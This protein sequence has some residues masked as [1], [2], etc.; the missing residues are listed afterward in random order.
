M[1][2]GKTEPSCT[3]RFA[4]WWWRPALVDHGRGGRRAHRASAHHVRAHDSRVQRAPWEA[5]RWR[6]FASAQL[7]TGAAV[8]VQRHHRL[9]AR[10]ELDLGHR[11][12][13]APHALPEE[14]AERV[15]E[16]RRAVAAQHARGRR[17]SPGWKPSRSSAITTCRL[18]N[19]LHP[20]ARGR[21][22]KPGSVMPARI[23]CSG[24]GLELEA[25]RARRRGRDVEEVIRV[26]RLRRAVEAVHRLRHRP[27][28]KPRSDA[29]TCACPTSACGSG[30]A[31][32]QQHRG[33]ADGAGGEDEVARRAGGCGAAR[34]ARPRRPRRAPRTA[35][36]AVAARRRAARRARDARSVAPCA[37][38]AGMVV[39]SIDCFALVGHPM[40]Q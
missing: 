4:R 15:V 34:A 2:V 10:R 33:A 32:A 31:A 29:G 9:R 36:I 27:P 38:A 19:S 11:E 18:A 5:P 40:P 28:P 6:R 26:D 17:A 24:R 16:H 21:A 7:A 35:T 20:R 39:T 23:G 25:D 30:S 14:V 1:L 22:P 8:L 3:E 37:S 13:G 12:V